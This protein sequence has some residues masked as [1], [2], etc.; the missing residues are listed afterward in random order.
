M[1]QYSLGHTTVDNL[2]MAENERVWT[3]YMSLR[4]GRIRERMGTLGKLVLL[5]TPAFRVTAVSVCDEQQV[6]MEQASL[7]CVS[8]NNTCF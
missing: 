4:V 5:Y 2:S 7:R 6:M 8:H 1:S 3:V